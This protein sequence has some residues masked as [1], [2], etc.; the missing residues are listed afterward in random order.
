MYGPSD[1]YGLRTYAGHMGQDI[2]RILTDKMDGY[3]PY[4]LATHRGVVKQI[5]QR[6]DDPNDSERYIYDITT[7]TGL[8]YVKTQDSIKKKLADIV[9]PTFRVNTIPYGQQVVLSTYDGVWY[10][11]YA[12]M[13]AV[14][15]QLGEDG[16]RT[17]ERGDAIGA[18]GETGNSA[19]VHL[20]Y[21]ILYCGNDNRDFH[22]SPGKCRRLNPFG[23]IEALRDNFLGIDPSKVRS[24]FAGNDTA[25]QNTAVSST[26]LASTAA[27]NYNSTCNSSLASQ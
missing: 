17:V 21:E 15:P 9:D 7:L 24:V 20:H 3:L 25:R 6:R 4:L 18:M 26:Q 16:W 19:G 23:Y 10:T 8:E 14:A 1:S 12:H 5:Q 2:S 22:K 13:D 27:A 11:R